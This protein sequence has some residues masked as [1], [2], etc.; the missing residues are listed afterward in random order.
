MSGS[1]AS[2]DP[3]PAGARPAAVVFGCAGPVLTVREQA[4]FRAVNPFGFILFRRNVQTP[5]QV[6]RL[7]GELR[8]SVRRPDA[9]V[10][11]D[12]EG[13]RVARLGPPHWPVHPPA[14]RIGGLA[15]HDPAA[16][17]EAAWLN[18]RLLAAMLAEL[19]ISVDCAPVCDVPVAGAHEV[20]GDRAFGTDPHLVARLARASCEG[21]LAG[22]I[23]P[24][25]KHL[26]GHGR[27][28]A[29]SHQ[30]LPVVTAPR[31]ALEASDLVPFRMLSDMPLGMVAH[32]VFTALDAT[33]PA[34]VS[35]AVIGG[36]IRGA[37]GYDGLLISDDLGMAAL[38]GD[39]AA[40]TR[41]VL[42]A[43]CDIAL[44]CS[45]DLAEMIDVAR[46]APPMGAAS[47]ARWERAREVLRP[48]APLDPAAA[49]R[50]LETLLEHAP[51]PGVRAIV[52]G[53]G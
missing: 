21:L 6:R 26:P 29:D 19:G 30:A 44:H 16:G 12:Q 2:F 15:E 32:V 4:F 34:S 7:V 33:R 5:D 31:A 8:A 37:L 20:I 49:R 51:A 41:A 48:P 53:E 50:R 46:A 39:M 13:G 3:A 36:L 47:W 22:G 28:E 24:V 14:R 25:I 38:S 17:Q 11:I 9:P 52:A 23:L 27:A 45:G 42:A 10:F 40:R 1:E 43:G 18:A 35:P